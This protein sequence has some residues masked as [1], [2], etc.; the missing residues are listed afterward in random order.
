MITS[1]IHLI[2][3]ELTRDQDF[4]MMIITDRGGFPCLLGPLY[5]LLT[6][7]LLVLVLLLPPAA[8]HLLLTGWCYHEIDIRICTDY[9]FAANVYIFEAIF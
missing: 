8:H 7:K 2:M 6:L 5:P 1:W 4:V 9:D 3:R